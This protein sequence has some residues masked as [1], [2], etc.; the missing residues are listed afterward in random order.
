MRPLFGPLAGR[1]RELRKAR[2]FFRGEGD[3]HLITLEVQVQGV[4]SFRATF[5]NAK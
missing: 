4:K 5:G 2:L 1:R 3:M